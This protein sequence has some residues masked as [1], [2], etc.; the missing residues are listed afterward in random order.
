MENLIQVSNLVTG[1]EKNNVILQNINLRINKGEF[2]GI[3]GK[4]GAG[5]STLLKT[6][7]GFLPYS[8]GSVELMG[9]ALTDTSSVSLP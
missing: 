3:I 2:I 4:N 9:K 7:R 8:S 1:Y 5:K 6:L